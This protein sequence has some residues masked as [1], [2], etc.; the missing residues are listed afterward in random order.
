M[1]KLN[2][3]KLNI[4]KQGTFTILL[5]AAV[6]A[7]PTFYWG[8]A[9]AASDDDDNL[10]IEE[11]IVTGTR[12]Q[13]PGLV[14]SSPIYSVK[15][16]EIERQQEPEVE[17]ILRLLPI[18]LPGDN[19]NVNNGTRGAAT[20]DLRGLGP[21]RSVTLMN[22][23]RLTPFNWNGFVDVSSVPTALIE[24]IDILTGGASTVYGSDAISGALNFI[25]KRDFEGVDI[26]A[27][28]SRY[29]EV[30]AD[31]ADFEG[32][33]D[34]VSIT[35]GSN[36]A[37]GRGNAVLH[38]NWT[39]RQPVLLG[40]RPFGRLGINTAPDDA[41]LPESEWTNA[42]LD[43]Y[44]SGAGNIL[45]A[46]RVATV[47]PVPRTLLSV[48]A[49]LP[50]SLPVSR[51][52]VAVLLANSAMTEPLAADAPDLTLTPST[53]SRLLRKSMA[54]WLLAISRLQTMLRYIPK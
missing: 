47:A 40:S 20:V 13:A 16:D 15:A 30:D 14:S 37:D 42:G 54:A 10:D 31:S 53:T 25:M 32:E 43:S 18:T 27:T 41:D 11:V 38:L 26:R 45:P 35:M 8:V 52:S 51:L 19:Q 2:T 6:I 48:P 12:I 36:L 5:A 7:L 22:G 44:N 34:S 1:Y 29:S 9:Q 49:R 50:L 21:E 46:D 23:L 28:H 33:T 39:D 4:Y 24:R 3:Y 17:K